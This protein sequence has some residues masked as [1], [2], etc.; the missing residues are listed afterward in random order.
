[1]STPKAFISYS[2]DDEPH[3]EWVKALAARLRSEGIDVT[4][5]RWAVAPGDQLPRFMETAVRENDFVLIVCTP[6][7]KLKSDGRK[8]G[9]GYEGDIMT[10]E[11]FSG[12]DHRKF[13]PVLRSGGWG[14]ASP[15]WLAGRYGIDLRGDPYSEVR[16]EDLLDTLH[17]TREQAPPVGRRPVRTGGDKRPHLASDLESPDSNV[18]MRALTWIAARGGGEEVLQKVAHLLLHDDLDEARER[19]AQALGR[20]KREEA[21]PWLI[22]GLN[23]PVWE[24][25]S[26]VGW[27]LVNLGRVAAGAVGDV[28]RNCHN[29]GA[30]EMAAMILQ[31]L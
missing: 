22:Q 2:W 14:D 25:R 24:V 8:G 3:K 12:K 29:P 13:I 23:D 18:R 5:D 26:A 19:A 31:K 15:S 9:V 20:L 1:V 21:I 16:Y 10:G 28:A 7:Y 30:R 11:V 6:S 17:G 4:L 27:A